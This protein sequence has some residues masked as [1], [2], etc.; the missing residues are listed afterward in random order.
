[1][2]V[3][4]VESASDVIQVLGGSVNAKQIEQN[5]IPDPDG[6]YDLIY[7]ISVLEHIDNPNVSLDEMGR[8]LKQNGLLVLTFDIDL[9]GDCEIGPE[10]FA[11][12]VE[13]MQNQFTLF[14]PNSISHPGAYLTSQNSP[15]PYN[16]HSPVGIIRAI[17]GRFLRGKKLFKNVTQVADL[18]VY[19]CVLQKT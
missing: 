16:H 15:F 2:C 6:T 9:R 1:M 14:F 10:K 3:R 8:V 19:S 5:A 17:A 4:D 18:A 13:S 7:C 11:R 12:L